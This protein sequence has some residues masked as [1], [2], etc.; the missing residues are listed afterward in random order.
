MC[1][2]QENRK[3]ENVEQFY[4]LFKELAEKCNFENRE[5]MIIR[6][7]FMTNMLD[8]DI[9]RDFLRDTVDPE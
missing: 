6:D 1:F 4:R 3:N 7:I 8:D 9:Q 2:S 5:E